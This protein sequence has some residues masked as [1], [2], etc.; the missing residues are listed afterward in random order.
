M[1]K[2]GAKKG[3]IGNGISREGGRKIKN[4]TCML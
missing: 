1:N 3:K 4:G 2:I